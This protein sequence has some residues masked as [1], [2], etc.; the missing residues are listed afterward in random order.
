MLWFRYAL[1]CLIYGVLD[2]ELRAFYVL[3][4]HSTNQATSLTLMYYFT[5]VCVVCS[6]GQ[7]NQKRVSDP[8]EFEQVGYEQPSKGAGN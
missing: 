1:L 3:G 7:R 6:G 4:K 8:L 5:C 2:I